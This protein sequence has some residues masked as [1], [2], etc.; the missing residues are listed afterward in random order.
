MLWRFIFIRVGDEFLDLYVWFY[1]IMSNYSIIIFVLY[2]CVCLGDMR[3]LV[4]L[5][6]SLIC[7]KKE[8]VMKL[9]SNK[10]KIVDLCLL[11]ERWFS[12]IN[13]LFIMFFC[14]CFNIFY[15]SCFVL[16]LVDDFSKSGSYGDMNMCYYLL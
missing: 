8:V 11:D 14:V 10:K 1:L 15:V 6:L 4:L 9:V 7:Y 12:E 3:D 2:V 16:V 5:V 13:L